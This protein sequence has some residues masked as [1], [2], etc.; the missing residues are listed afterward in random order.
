MATIIDTLITKFEF[1]TNKKG[2]EK[3]ESSL[4]SFKN[5]AMKSVGAIAGVL[6]GGALFSGIVEK[7]NQMYDLAD[8]VGLT[9]QQMQGL[10]LVASNAGV[11]TGALESSLQR[12]NV[13]VGQTARGYGIYG[14][15]LAQYGVSIRSS[16]GSLLST[17]QII[18]NINKQFANLS[19][20]Q[21][22]DL[23]QNLGINPQA[24]QVFQTAPKVFESLI[25]ASAQLSPLTKENEKRFAMLRQ[26]TSLLKMEFFDFGV[27]IANILA[28]TI[29]FLTKS[30]SSLL[31]FVNKNSTFFKI[32]AGALG[33]T[34]LAT[35]GMAIATGLL[36][37]ALAVLLS[38]I[39]LI[40]AGITALA[41]EID[42]LYAGL[43]G[44]KSVIF[45][46]VNWLSNLIAQFKVGREVIFGMQD[47]IGFIIN[48]ILEIPKTL[49]KTA[50]DVEYYFDK[51]KNFF[52]GNKKSK[53]NINAA[54]NTGNNVPVGATNSSTV[55]SQNT[56]NTQSINFG[57][58]NING[59]GTTNED[60]AR[61]IVNHLNNERKTSSDHFDSTIAR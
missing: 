11:S 7:T 15:V 46:A 27:S 48:S 8:S 4:M 18:Q 55:N 53:L 14:Q 54:L 22:F 34:T 37:T 58:I 21:Q 25:K 59:N 13:V 52:E 6:G 32:L 16:N 2:L 51:I 26:Q 35:K 9:A 19:K 29:T 50:K 39:T 44:G 12:L 49:E 56:T 30:F 23:A 40:V 60:V 45:N 5:I 1:E 3:A 20:A 42:D 10:N 47:A 24:I 43:N 38:P 31:I 41:L 61:V 17:F 33:V 57:D 28:P 36:D